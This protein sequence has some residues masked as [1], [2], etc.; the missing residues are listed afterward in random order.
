LPDAR[1]DYSVGTPRFDAGSASGP[2]R[3]LFCG[4]RISLDQAPTADSQSLTVTVAEPQSFGPDLCWYLNPAHAS[5][6][7]DPYRRRAQTLDHSGFPS[8][9]AKT[10]VPI[11][12]FAEAASHWTK[13]PSKE[14]VDAIVEM[15]RRN[16][17]WGCPRI[18]QQITLAF[19]LEIDKDVVRRVLA[20]EIVLEGV[21]GL[22][23][24]DPLV[25]PCGSP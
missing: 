3:P 11:V 5:V 10:K 22:P 8:N 6:S 14:L 15:K 18:A 17:I 12:V 9:F 23:T 20:D 13:G 21:P 25:A 2:R 19:D 16:P 24:R 1:A 7:D 4:G